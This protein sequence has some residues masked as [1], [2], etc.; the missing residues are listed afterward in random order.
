MLVQGVTVERMHNEFINGLSHSEGAHL[1]LKVILCFDDWNEFLLG[2]CVFT[3]VLRTKYKHSSWRSWACS[4]SCC[5]AYLFDTTAPTASAC[6]VVKGSSLTILLTL[7][8]RLNPSTLPIQKYCE[9]H[10]TGAL[11]C[12]SLSCLPTILQSK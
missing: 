6:I 3:S 8:S 4:P 12:R 11:P 5:L 10:W 7:L 2:V 1:Y 9:S